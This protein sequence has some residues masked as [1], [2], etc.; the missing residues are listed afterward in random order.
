LRRKAD[1]SG[2]AAAG[3]VANGVEETRHCYRDQDI[4]TQ[5]KKTNN[6]VGGNIYFS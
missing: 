6:T 3:K 1:F 2:A 5:C 4:P